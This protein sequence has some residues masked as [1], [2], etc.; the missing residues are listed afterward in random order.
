MAKPTRMR[1]DLFPRKKGDGGNRRVKS[2]FH[3]DFP[4]LGVIWY[5]YVENALRSADSG[6]A[7]KES[8]T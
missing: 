5:K 6:V 4:E 3:E 1:C 7:P 2:S 8:P